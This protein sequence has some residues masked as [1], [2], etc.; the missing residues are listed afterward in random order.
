MKYWRS[1]LR[2][3]KSIPMAALLPVSAAAL[4]LAVLVSLCMGAVSLS[5]GELLQMPDILRY[6]RIPRVAAA[7]FAGA[8]L[9]GAGVIIQT[10][11]GN[12]LAGPNIIGVNAGAG[13]MT[14]TAGIL[15]PLIPIM[16]PA[17]AFLGALGA[18]CLVYLLSRRAGSSRMTI[19]LAGMVINSL[20]NAIS[21]ALYT[22]FPDSYSGY[23]A[24]RVGGLKA[25]RTDVLVPAMILIALAAL[26]VLLHMDALELLSL[27]DET[28]FSLGLPV[29]GF[30]LLFLICAA[31]MAGAVVSFAGL[32]G[33]LGLIVPHA[34]RL[35]VGDEIRKLF[36]VSLLWGA[37]LLVVCDTAA[38]T[39]FAPFE[40][41]VGIVVSVIGAPVFMAMLLKRRRW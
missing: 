2:T 20:F 19:L 6:I 28:A 31:C 17:M 21:E 13:L 16:Q 30:R 15:F 27:G 36:P 3:I 10:L 37:L 40:L 1:C 41:S 24:F 9:A 33:F 18:V 29:K 35:V 25:V 7:V 11:L 34:A 23:A 5:L 8:G 39:A 26:A 38:R 22:F 14:L 12:H 32:I 4:G